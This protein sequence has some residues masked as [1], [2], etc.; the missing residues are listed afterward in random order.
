MDRFGSADL[1]TRSTV[2]DPLDPVS[3]LEQLT[4]PCVPPYGEP[5]R[6]PGVTQCP[7]ASPI[8]GC[9]S[10]Q[11]GSL[12]ATCFPSPGEPTASLATGTGSACIAARWPAGSRSRL[13]GERAAEIPAAREALEEAERLE[14]L[15]SVFRE[16][17][18]ISRINQQAGIGAIAASNDVVALLSRC[19]QLSAATGGAFDIT[20]TPLSRC[21][22]FLRRDGR[23]P[24]DSE[25]D[26]ALALVG[27]DALSCD[28]ETNRVSM[29]TPGAAV[30]LGA[31][32]KGFAVQA[33]GAALWRQGVREALV[34][35]GS[36]SILALGGTD[37]GWRVDVTA[38]SPTRR[39][40][41]RLRLRNAALGTSGAGEQFVEVNGR[42]YGHILDPAHRT[43]R[44]RRRQRDGRQRRR[45]HRR[46]TRDGV[47][48]RRHRA[49]A[50][51]TAT[52]TRARS[53]S[54]PRTT[55]PGVL[56]LS[57]ATLAPLWRSCEPH[58]RTAGDRPAQLPESRRRGAR[59]RRALAPPRPISGPVRG[60]PMRIG[61]IG[62]GGE[63]R[64]LLAQ[65]DPAY[66]TV[67][68]MADINPSQL[69]KSDE[70]L[71]K[72]GR[73][74]AKHYAD[75]QDMIAHED[76]EG[77]VVAVPLWAHADVVC[78]CLDAG[79]HVLCEKMMAWDV[80]G[81]ERMRQTALK[82]RK[83]LE[84]GYQRNYNPMYQAAH[85]G[86]IK[87][88]LL[89]DVFLSRILWHR[90]GN[91][92]RQGE[93]PSKDYNPSKWG[94]PTS[95]TCGTGG[96]TSATRAGYR[97]TGQPRDEHRQLV[98]RRGADVGDGHRRHL[99]L[100]RR[101]RGARPRVRDVEYHGRTHGG[102]LLDRVER[103]R[104]LLRGVLRHE[105]DADPA[106]RGRGLPLRRVDRQA[107]D[108]PRGDAKGQGPALE[109]SESRVADAAG[110]GAGA[111][112]TTGDRLL[113]HKNEIS[114]FCSA[115]R[116]GAPLLCGP[117]R[118]MGSARACIAAVEAIEK[119]TRLEIPP[120]TAART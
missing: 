97:G 95:S 80:A 25:I 65:V 68:A 48:R 13:S 29:S 110:R 83:V 5:I 66:A 9:R 20:S 1:W 31:V 102:L 30:N 35:A 22:G 38:T 75:W 50:P 19:R 17:S 12:D 8:H 109:A 79:K 49:G 76:I 23:V 119:K 57:G 85:D 59:A 33:I 117:D 43:S 45:R 24:A 78:G 18:E 87:T 41:A 21:W 55:S 113:V 104:P 10:P 27:M 101:A 106:G 99:P 116:T 84:I 86:I 46:R 98:L 3:Q 72:Q 42:R 115:V 108:R 74:A 71:Q 100:Q 54:S 96:S 58:A 14:A 56:A 73:P 91:W 40:L 63:G 114:A 4:S 94:Y 81:C 37:D 107:G 36:S 111:S 7:L 61:F 15:L 60:G 67:A 34:S 69:A 88:G 93:P 112:T 39:V 51:A 89:G 62:V 6:L 120:P 64:V 118:A 105:G 28:V 53:R 103:V 47:L 32:G 92:R 26:Q 70:V 16:T 2:H 52:R 90:N 82:N 11:R 44:V 77:V